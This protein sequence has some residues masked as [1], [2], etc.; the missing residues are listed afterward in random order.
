MTR[1][2]KK[3]QGQ[4]RRQRGGD[5]KPQP[6]KQEKELHNLIMA[7]AKDIY[8]A[9]AGQLMARG[10]GT[11]EDYVEMARESVDTSLIWAREVL[12]ITAQRTAPAQA[13]KGAPIPQPIT[14]DAPPPPVK[15]VIEE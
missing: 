4:P 15:P 2:T 9:A 3:Y 11:E 6:S 5:A 13:Q 1:R 12:G 14:D 10:E 7:H 8:A